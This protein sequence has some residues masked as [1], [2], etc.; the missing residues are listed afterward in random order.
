MFRRIMRFQFFD[1]LSRFLRGKGFIQVRPCMRVEIIL[2]QPETPCRWEMHL[3][4][5]LETLRIIQGRPLLGNFY[6]SPASQWV[7]NHEKI[8][9]SLP[10][11]CVIFPISSPRLR[12]QRFNP[13]SHQ[14]IRPF[15]KTDHGTVRIKRLGLQIKDVFHMI[16]EISMQLADTPLTPMP[17]LD[18]VFF[19]RSRTVSS[20]ICSISCRSRSCSASNSIV[21]AFRPSGGVEHASATT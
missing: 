1:Q 7:K 5:V 13:V 4:N 9:D 19:K 2:N 21:Q 6:M 16:H 15:I 18:L 14:L 10:F 20:E 3:D 8:A 17:W 12:K 11:I